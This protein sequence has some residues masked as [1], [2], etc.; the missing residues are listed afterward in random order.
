MRVAFQPMQ[1]ISAVAHDAATRH[2]TAA[3]ETDI[4]PIAINSSVL[5]ARSAGPELQCVG[6]DWHGGAR[7]RESCLAD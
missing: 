1:P 6:L 4:L 2:P 5:L 3:F 7:Q